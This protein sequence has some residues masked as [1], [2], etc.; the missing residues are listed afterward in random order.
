MRH[1]TPLGLLGLTVCGLVAW[2]SSQGLPTR[3]LK[4]QEKL[5]AAAPLG[6][7]SFEPKSAID[8]LT[9]NDFRFSS[10]VWES[11]D[12]VG[13]FLR[14][15]Y[16]ESPKNADRAL[17]QKAKSASRILENITL[18]D[19]NG[20]RLGRRIVAS[21]GSDAT[22]RQLILWTDGNVFYSVESSSFQHALIF[23]KR[24]PDL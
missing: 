2:L 4:Y 18:R 17:L 15:Q 6:A 22:Q 14:R 9:E 11:N 23:E 3:S 21:F 1:P 13:I 24:L 5:R 10:E 12:G 19:K 7:I 16:C 20:S 8:G